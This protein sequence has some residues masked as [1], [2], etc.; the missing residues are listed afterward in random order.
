MGR[1]HI[2]RAAIL[3]T[4]KPISF[5]LHL[6]P[7]ELD[8]LSQFVGGILGQEGD[9]GQGISQTASHSNTEPLQNSLNK[10]LG[11]RH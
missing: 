11:R 5:E 8:L 10:D 6:L 3:P 1:H 7:K 2:G 9:L 4:L